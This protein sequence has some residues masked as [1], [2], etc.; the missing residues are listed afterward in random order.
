M[1]FCEPL[2]TKVYLVPQILLVKN[3]SVL[4]ATAQSDSHKCNDTEHHRRHKLFF[5]GLCNRITIH[6]CDP[7]SRV[8]LAICTSRNRF[9]FKYSGSGLVMFQHLCRTLEC[10]CHQ[11]WMVFDLCIPAAFYRRWHSAFLMALKTR[12]GISVRNRP[13]LR[14]EKNSPGSCLLFSVH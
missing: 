2:F 5:P 8:T 10:S 3:V 1:S 11:A 13:H 4:S 6:R 7:V 14:L 9:P 12:H